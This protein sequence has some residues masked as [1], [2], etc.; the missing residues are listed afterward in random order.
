MPRTP[1]VP[2]PGQRL[3]HQT[4][5]LVSYAE[6]KYSDEQMAVAVAAYS[7]AGSGVKAR[8]LLE[9]LWGVGATLPT[10]HTIAVWVNAGVRPADETALETITRFDEARRKH[11]SFELFEHYQQSLIK[12]DLDSEKLFNVQGGYGI[13]AQTAKDAFQRPQGGA[14]LD[15]RGA[16]FIRNGD[17]PVPQWDHEVEAKE[18]DGNGDG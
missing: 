2:G 11:L 5:E 6:P 15:M 3:S 16:T 17:K 1:P 12:R 9:G 10:P 7:V 18:V 13:A 4:H 8:K 14:L